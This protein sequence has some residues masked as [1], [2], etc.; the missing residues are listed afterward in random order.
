[1]KKSWSR[2]GLQTLAAGIWLLVCWIPV[3]CQARS[4]VAQ[5]DP[6][7]TATA[8][9]GGKGSGLVNLLLI[10]QDQR[11]GEV[12]S[13]ADTIVLC[14]FHKEEDKITLT[15][16]LRDLYVDIPG[17][18]SNRL[19]AAYALGG[20]ALLRQ[21][22]EENFGILIDG[23]IEV[24]FGQFCQLVELQGGIRLNLRQDEADWINTNVENSH[25]T[26]GLQQLNGSQALAYARIRNLDPD[27][28][29]S[30][31]NRH[32]AILTALL[33]NCQDIGLKEVRSL[34]NSASDMIS[35]DM[36]KTR[37]IALAAELFPMIEDCQLVSQRIPADGTY[38]N[39]KI[40]GMAVLA[41]DMNAARELLQQSLGKITQ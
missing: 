9:I 18:R 8:K 13:R 38:T 15:S 25:L 29:F 3:L 6:Q 31:T 21:T 1:M 5:K 10:G 27:G 28:D 23:C 36:K 30:R 41:A 22:L 26:Q 35:T 40:H 16:F 11:E 32:R 33:G 2:R 7:S 17:H 19:N 34:L 39:E 37:M 20:S 24:D 12:G 4:E 14:T